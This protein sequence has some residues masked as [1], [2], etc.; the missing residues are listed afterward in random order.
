MQRETE[1]ALLSK[2][3][4]AAAR[5]ARDQARGAFSGQHHLREKRTFPNAME[6]LLIFGGRQ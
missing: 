3:E 2:I 6:E 1:E 4:T 5:P